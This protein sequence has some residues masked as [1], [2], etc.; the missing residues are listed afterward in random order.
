MAR[1]K[2][3]HSGWHSYGLYK[4]YQSPA[5]DEPAPKPRVKKKDTNKWCRGKVGV[6]HD[7]HRFEKLPRSF[8]RDWAW[9]YVDLK[10]INCG[11]KG[12]VKPKKASQYTFHIFVDK[13]Y[14]EP[15][16]VPVRH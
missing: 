12:Y 15:Y 6:K 8:E 13:F 14:S 4:K 1:L 3:D 5:V 16:E 9:I 2:R 11:K 10:C 7:Y